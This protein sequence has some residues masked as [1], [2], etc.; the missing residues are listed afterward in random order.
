MQSCEQRRRDFLFTADMDD[1]LPK[2]SGAELSMAFAAATT[3][4]DS[5]FRDRRIAHRIEDEMFGRISTEALRLMRL[6]RRKARIDAVN[7]VLGGRFNDD[8]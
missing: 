5:R 4:S 3:L 6:G 2:M 7:M 8:N 1:L